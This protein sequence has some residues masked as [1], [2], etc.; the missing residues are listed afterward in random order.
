ML[1]LQEN[2]LAC[3]CM[4]WVCVCVCVCE[5]IS[6]HQHLQKRLSDGCQLEIEPLSVTE[7]V[8]L[9]LSLS[10]SSDMCSPAK[11]SPTNEP[12]S[13]TEKRSWKRKR[14][15][16][17][18]RTKDFYSPPPPPPPHSESWIFVDAVVVVLRSPLGTC[19]CW[20][21]LQKRCG[22]RLESSSTL[23]AGDILKTP[24]VVK[25]FTAV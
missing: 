22:V 23:T 19:Q 18:R 15:S 7:R 5:R 11:I 20:H 2:R 25:H 12:A 14:P 16:L 1:F 9:S 4:Q 6:N 21:V 13:T 17:G 3:S 24:K 8:F 10:L